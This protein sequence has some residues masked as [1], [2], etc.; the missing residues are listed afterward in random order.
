M[1]GA[2][3][4]MFSVLVLMSALL[5]C[6]DEKS[7]H[8]ARRVRDLQK[9]DVDS[10]KGKSISTVLG[11][12]ADSVERVFVSHEPPGYLHSVSYCFADGYC[13]D[14]LIARPQFQP[15]YSEDQLWDTL[16]LQLETVREASLRHRREILFGRR[17]N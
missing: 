8:D 13:L 17:F 5:S 15:V 16:L 6:E 2:V 9:A 12:L 14:F 11:S 10:F 7:H 4:R 1:S 3:T